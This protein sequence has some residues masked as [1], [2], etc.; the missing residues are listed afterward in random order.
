MFIVEDQLEITIRR[1][2]RYMLYLWSSSIYI[3]VFMGNGA[4]RHQKVKQS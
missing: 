1:N 3:I 2:G 4:Q